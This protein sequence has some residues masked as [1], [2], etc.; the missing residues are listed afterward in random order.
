MSGHSKWSQIKHQ[1]GIADQK[2]GQVFSRLS[3]IISLAA[4]K[5][6]DP[7]KNFEL[8][9][10]IEKARAANMPKETIE[11]AVKRV[12]DKEALPLEELAIEAVG[13]EAV[14][15]II[16]AIT[17]NRN[18]TIAEIKKVLSHHGAKMAQPGAVRWAFEK[19]NGDFVPKY[20]QE[21]ANKENRSKLEKLLKEL[22]DLEDV[23]EIYT[24]Y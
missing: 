6:T 3:K 13:L 10:A 12:G 17:D 5:G 16:T 8:K 22:D 18:R 24:N 9:N 4:R 20:P 14:N 11:R 19:K 1:K 23:Q 2:K 7:E 21:I 15:I